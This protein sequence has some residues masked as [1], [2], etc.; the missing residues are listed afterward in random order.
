MPP[1]SPS[2]LNSSGSPL[3]TPY[4]LRQLAELCAAHPLEPKILLAPGVRAGY[5]LTTALA[6]SGQ[7][8][9]NLRVTTPVL[10]AAEQMEPQMAALGVRRLRP[11]GRRRL[12]DALLADWPLAERRYF[13]GMAAGVRATDAG[14]AQSLYNTFDALRLAHVLPEHM[15]SQSEAGLSTGGKVADL[16]DLY[17]RYVEALHTGSWWDDA[18][19]L[20]AAARAASEHAPTNVIWVILDEVD[21]PPLAADYVSQRAAGRL[22]RLGRRAYGVRPPTFSAATRFPRAPIPGENPGKKKADP[23]LAPAIPPRKAETRRQ[24]AER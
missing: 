11:E 3:P 14:V 10:D 19:L 16:A 18:A 1:C 12:V 13:R 21:L 17:D 5:D 20:T 2:T 23:P 9:T 15:A 8:W 22:W 7:Q 4:P 6:R 24:T